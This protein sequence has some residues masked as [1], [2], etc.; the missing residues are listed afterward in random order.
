MMNYKE[1]GDLLISS[2]MDAFMPLKLQEV[3]WTSLAATPGL[4][5]QV[6]SYTDRHH[7]GY[8]SCTHIYRFSF[9]GFHPQPH[10]LVD[11][12]I[13]LQT[14][15]QDLPQPP[16]APLDR[17]LSMSHKQLQ[18]SDMIVPSSKIRLMETLG[19]GAV[20]QPSS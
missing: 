9:E 18:L 11:H 5:L 8:L 20:D 12:R 17:P 6:A 1:R 7:V 16:K 2:L 19:E 13:N 14:N 10:P 15:K 4:C 3:V